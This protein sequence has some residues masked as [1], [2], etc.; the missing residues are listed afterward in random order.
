MGF[1]DALSELNTSVGDYFGETV[2]Y[3]SADGGTSVTGIA[4]TVVDYMDEEGSAMIDVPVASVSAPTVGGKL[5]L[6]DSS[7]WRI[8]DF[9][10]VKWG[11][12][13]CD[14]R[15]DSYWHT[16]V[17]EYY[18]AGAWATW[19]AAV[20]V[21]MSEAVAAEFLDGET[22]HVE[23]TYTARTMFQATPTEKMR[24]NLGGTFYY[25]SGI[26]PDATKARYLE[27]DLVRRKQ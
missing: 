18:T 22:A 24:F 1:A 21:Y 13:P 5:T 26:S 23:M 4:D 10:N 20:E 11:Y 9:G 19:T 8:Y 25:I 27:M 6:A 2:D 3:L 16:C 17:L 15:E 7:V 14:I 12:T